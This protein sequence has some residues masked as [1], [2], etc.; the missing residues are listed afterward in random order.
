MLFRSPVGQVVKFAVNGPN[1]PGSSGVLSVDDTGEIILDKVKVAKLDALR[2][3]RAAMWY[4]VIDATET[5]REAP[6]FEL[7]V[8]VINSDAEDA[9]EF[10][11][12]RPR[13]LYSRW[14]GSAN[15]LAASIWVNRQLDNFK[16]VPLEISLSLDPKDYE[17]TVGN[18]MI[19]TTDQVVGDTGASKAV[20][21]LV[22]SAIDRG[23]RIDYRI[24]STSSDRR[25]PFIAPNGTPDHPTDTDYAHI[26]NNSG[27]MGDGSPAYIIF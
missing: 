10:N 17:V 4:D 1:P 21:G 27:L 13:D 15:A 22:V 19:I 16:N 26:S 23:R 2:I 25:F 3:T 8:M 11:D 6:N 12:V 9:N 14:F 7:G 20:R 5:G 24:R 18:E